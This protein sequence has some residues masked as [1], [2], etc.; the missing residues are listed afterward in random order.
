VRL[1]QGNQGEVLDTMRP[2]ALSGAEVKGVVDLW[3]GC[4]PIPG[5]VWRK[6]ATG[7]AM[8]GVQGT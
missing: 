6:P 7:Q 2:E 8:S 1:P 3:L 4:L 5:A